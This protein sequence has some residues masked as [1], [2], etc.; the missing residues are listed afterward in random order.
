MKTHIINFIFLAFS[1]IFI[2]CKEDPE[3]VVGRCNSNDKFL[4][5]T[6]TLKLFKDN[7]FMYSDSSLNR[8][9]ESDT[10]IKGKYIIKN[11]TIYFQ[12][13]FYYFKKGILTNGYFE[14]LSPRPLKFELLKNNSQINSEIYTDTKSDFTF[15]TYTKEYF[16]KDLTGKNSSLNEDEILK[17]KSLI[18]STIEKNRDKFYHN[19]NE[20]DYYKQCLVIINSKNEK[21]VSIHCIGKKGNLL[22]WKYQPIIVKDGGDYFFWIRINLTKNEVT[23]L[24]VNGEA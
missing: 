17:V 23:N 4:G 2:S 9:I 5:L 6:R 15:F 10:I 7:T 11:D 16:G 21:E 20:G 14:L 12:D 24:N 19:F 8:G 22:D 1:L 3:L 18:Q 13:R